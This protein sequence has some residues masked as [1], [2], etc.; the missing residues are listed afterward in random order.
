MRRARSM[1]RGQAICAA[2]KVGPMSLRSGCAAF[3]FDAL[4][5]DIAGPV[6]P[7][8]PRAN[9]GAMRAIFAASARR[10]AGFARQ[11]AICRLYPNSLSLPAVA[12]DACPNLRANP[13][14]YFN[15]RRQTRG[16]TIPRS[17]THKALPS[18]RAVVST[19]RREGSALS[20]WKVFRAPA[21]AAHSAHSGARGNGFSGSS[22]RRRCPRW[23]AAW[24]A[25]DSPARGW[26]AH[27]KSARC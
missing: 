9:A 15:L 18:R 16:K 8:H 14:T 7:A 21:P 17:P 11:R 2:R 1:Q 3:S 10:F 13:T 4:P 23:S 25:G 22:P 20:L 12:D 27:G 24:G 19:V 6:L 5:G 26:R